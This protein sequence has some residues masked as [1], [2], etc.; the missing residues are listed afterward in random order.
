LVPKGNQQI[1]AINNLRRGP[2]GSEEVLFSSV[3][4]AQIYHVHQVHNNYLSCS[5]AVNDTNNPGISP[6]LVNIAKMPEMQQSEYDGLTVTDPT[7]TTVT[8][9]FSY[10]GT[11]LRTVTDANANTEDQVVVPRYIPVT[12]SWPGSRIVALSMASV[13]IKDDSNND[14]NVSLIEVGNRAW[15]KKPLV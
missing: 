10:T 8:W 11:Q 14:M 3:Q 5:I 15:A 9:T 13:T 6:I 12:G 1:D 2:I 7:D 4:A